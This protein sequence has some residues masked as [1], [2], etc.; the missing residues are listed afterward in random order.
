MPN[1]V[2]PIPTLFP[3]ASLSAGL[4]PSHPGDKDTPRCMSNVDV[5]YNPGEVWCP[6]CSAPSVWRDPTS[7]IE[8]LAFNGKANLIRLTSAS[9]R[10]APGTMSRAHLKSLRGLISYNPG[11]SLGEA[12]RVVFD[13]RHDENKVSIVSGGGSL[14]GRKPAR[15][16]RWAGTSLPA[17]LQNRSWP[18]STQCQA[19]RAPSSWSQTS[20]EIACILV[21]R[22]RRRLRGVTVAG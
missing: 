17:P 15:G 1:S 7:H 11:L 2:V 6:Y 22:T 19:R 21:L 18:P 8:R 16:P 9:A 20:L 3:A 4:L 5:W 14:R 12:N 13:T 10:L